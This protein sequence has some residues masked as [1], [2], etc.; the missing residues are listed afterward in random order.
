[1][2]FRTLT[3]TTLFGWT[4]GETRKEEENISFVGLGFSMNPTNF[5]RLALS[6]FKENV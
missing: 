5:S 4:E 2:R 1:M 3:F 6:N